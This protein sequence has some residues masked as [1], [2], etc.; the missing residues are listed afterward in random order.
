MSCKNL[1]KDEDGGHWTQEDGITAEEGQEVLCRSKNLPWNKGPG[2]DESGKKLTTSNV[3]IARSEGHKIIGSRYRIGGDVDTEGD[4][5]EADSGESGSSA[6]TRRARIHPVAD[7]YYR[8]PFDLAICGLS[9]GSSEDTKQTH[10]GEDEWDDQ[11]LHI[12]CAWL[13]GIT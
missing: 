9:C 6:S 4:D 2:A 5:D 8:I 10:N 3:D 1:L 12:L 11:D 7:D 13:V